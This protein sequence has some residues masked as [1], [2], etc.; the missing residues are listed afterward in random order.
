M[1]AS[2]K[3]ILVVDD[4]R[5]IL[6]SLQRILED[7]YAVITVLGGQAALDILAKQDGQVDVILC[8]LSMPTVDGADLYHKIAEIYPGLEER[9]IFM[10][11]GAYTPGVKEF[12]ARVKNV[13]LKKPFDEGE[14]ELALKRILSV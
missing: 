9:I 7:D 5:F 2:R 6:K 4:E 3:C 1:S 14:L 10:T 12:I 8:D 13:C 11:G